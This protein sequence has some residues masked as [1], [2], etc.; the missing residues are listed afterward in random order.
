MVGGFYKRLIRSVKSCLKKLLTVK[1]TDDE[2]N[3]II[4]ESEAV[5]ILI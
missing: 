3:T 1:V 2:L 5:L 4:T